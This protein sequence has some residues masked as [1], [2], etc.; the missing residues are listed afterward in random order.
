MKTLCIRSLKIWAA[1]AMMGGAGVHAQ[2]VRGVNPADIDSRFDVIVKH[3]EL[4]PTG[5]AD[6]ITFKYDHKLNQ[7]WGLN[8]ELPVYT[9]IA[10]PGMPASGNG[11]LFTRARWIV[12]AGK[13]TYGASVEG[14]FPGASEDALGTGKY[15]L[16]VAGLLVR[17][18]SQS[19]IVAAAVKRVTSFGGDNDRADFSNSEIRLVPVLILQDGWAI[20]GEM[21]Q[22]WEHRSD[23]SWQRIEVVL[24]KQFSARWAGSVG[25]GRDLGD[26]KDAGAVSIAAKYFF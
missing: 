8:F 19:F 5:G 11:D 18:V 15:Q 9:K 2:Q 26:R 21:R 25:L 6:S 22:T 1:L 3:V 7:N 4:D 12:P 14:V 16:N 13:W 17:S 24:N 20:T 23:L 10:V